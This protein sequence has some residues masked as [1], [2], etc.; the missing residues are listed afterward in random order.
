[1]NL[2]P[3][4]HYPSTLLPQILRELTLKS[5]LVISTMQDFVF[6]NKI[7]ICR[8]LLKD[9]DL[10]PCFDPHYYQCSRTTT[11]KEVEVVFQRA[12]RRQEAVS[13]HQYDNYQNS[14]LIG[15]R[16]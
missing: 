2:D 4:R 12:L 9:T 5:E 14:E 11:S 6:Y 1:M 16:W 3:A 13:K 7:I 8:E 10:F 15:I